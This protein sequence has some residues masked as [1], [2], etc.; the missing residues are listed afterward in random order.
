VIMASP[1]KPITVSAESAL[2]Q[3]TDEALAELRQSIVD[4]GV[5]E[6]ADIELVLHLVENGK[7]GT[8][9]VKNLVAEVAAAEEDLSLYA[10]RTLLAGDE[11]MAALIADK[12]YGME[13]VSFERTIVEDD[14]ALLITLDQARVW[15]MLP[16]ARRGSELL[17]AT[18][19]PTDMATRESL[20]HALPGEHIVYKFALGGDLAN[21]INKVYRD[22][23]PVIV[24][25]AHEYS[26]ANQP[27]ITDGSFN[28]ESFFDTL[29]R[30]AANNDV[31]DI[32]IEPKEDRTDIRFR[33]DGV[34]HAVTSVPTGEV[35]DRLVRYIK[36]KCEGSSMRADEKRQPQD[37]RMSF[38]LTVDQS[39]DIRVVTTPTIYKESVVMRLLDQ[40]RGA[41]SL[42]ELG[43]TPDNLA[44][45]E[46]AI[47]RP[48]GCCLLT[49]PTGSGKTTTLY[50]S[51]VH[52]SSPEIKIIA[53][54]DPVEYHL[55]D[56]TQMDVSGH[57]QSAIDFAKA[58]KS[59]LR[60][61]PDIIMIGEIRDAETA[62][63]AME[64]ALTG[65]FLY[66]TLHANDALAAIS[67]LERLDVKP[68][69]TA[70]AIAV[71]VAQRLVR[72]LCPE[73]K[74]A[75]EVNAE[76]LRGF[77][78]SLD[79]LGGKDSV[80]FYKPK[81]GGCPACRQEGYRGRTG[82]HEV[83]TLDDELRALIVADA[84]H[85]E[86][87]KFA[88]AHGM[89]SLRDDCC[90]KVIAGITSVEELARIAI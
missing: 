20:Q 60:A 27:P 46:R 22:A 23:E 42:E 66:S 26:F 2:S 63:T 73:C 33:V 1:R 29:I 87:V 31:S 61:D 14:V 68:F 78:M 30:E 76:Q 55:D 56:V 10:F 65:H 47:R 62:A 9:D 54:E 49:G 21:A 70:E 39:I 59:Q 24:K 80:R 18:S 48:H 44:R 25:R 32:H 7:L 90:L 13:A 17:V 50:S 43:M 6:D 58:L 79:V 57:G 88:R 19:N 64:A 77:D 89:H 83:V 12:K 15:R 84:P 81:I 86:L 75:Y 67:R 5:V 52:V 82:V 8:A 40:Q 38:E 72:K 71:L 4:A 51:L 16:Y 28:A 41:L 11:D 69:I 37:G 35:T 85:D 36:T 3:G 53:I 74:I 45:Y 34:L